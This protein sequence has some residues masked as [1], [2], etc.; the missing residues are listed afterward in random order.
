MAEILNLLRARAASASAR[1]ASRSCATGAR[2]T[3]CTLTNSSRA[4]S[5]FDRPRAASSTTRCSLGVSSPGGVA[6]A[7][8][9][10]L[11]LRARVLGPAVR[12]ERGEGGG[13]RLPAAGA[14]APQRRRRRA[15]TAQREQRPG[16]VE[17]QPEPLVAGGDLLRRLRL[18]LEQGR[19]AARRDQTPGML[20][21][22]RELAAAEQSRRAPRSRSPFSS[23]A[24]TRS[25]ATG[26]APGSSIPSRSRDLP[27]V[28]AGRPRPPA[29]RGRAAAPARAPAAS[30][31]VARPLRS[32]FA[33][34]IASRAERSA[35]SGSPRPAA[36]SV[37]QRS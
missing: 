12:A 26:K 28:A 8:A 9:D 34:A 25:G 36:S 11:E 13:G 14:R 32:P 24:S 37:R 16:P 1:R 22:D 15:A 2:S 3:V 31:A 4:I 18:V 30:P 21:G 20:L 33:A 27:D 17:R 10:A 23:S 29:D 19:A 35:S 6:P 7:P 5:L